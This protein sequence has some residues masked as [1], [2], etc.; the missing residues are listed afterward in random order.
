MSRKSEVAERRR[1]M[2]T[3][4]RQQLLAGMPA[5]ENRLEL[6]G[7]ST[8]VLEA[9]EGS[10][11]VLLHG[12]IQ[13]GG[14]YWGPVIPGLAEKYRLVVP[15][16]PGLGESQPVDRLDANFTEWFI[17][18]LRQTCPEPPILIAHSLVGSLA[19][20]FAAEHHDLVG[21]LV[22]YGAP[23]VSPH[24]LPLGLQA[25][26]VRFDL[27]PSEANLIRFERWAHLDL[28]GT[29]RR[30]P[31]WY[32]AFDGYMLARGVAPHVKRTMRQLITAGTKRIP[33]TELER[34]EVPTSLLWGRH[35]RMVPLSLGERTSSKLGWPLHV[36]DN[37]AH[38]P[39]MEQPGA[40]LRTLSDID[41][42]WRR[43]EAER[44]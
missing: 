11:V 35:D 10:P 9:G 1:R 16:V 34:I 41:S 26:G 20:R 15:D 12:G 29:R 13:C 40:F 8:S 28:D 38:V 19:V 24:R 22:V 2:G 4:S 21:R 39:H 17:A 6:A 5:K 32:E 30:E 31:E 25:A 44:T 33:D 7:V 14:V 37:A 18:L 3:N 36:V 23:G 43:R 27:R 42:F